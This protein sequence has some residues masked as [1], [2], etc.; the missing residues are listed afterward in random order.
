MAYRFLKNLALLCF[1]G[2]EDAPPPYTNV[3]QVTRQYIV[4]AEPTNSS[5]SRRLEEVEARLHKL[6]CPKARAATLAL[7]YQMLTI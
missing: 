1:S 7:Q 4:P 6:E 3:E 2:A 5:I